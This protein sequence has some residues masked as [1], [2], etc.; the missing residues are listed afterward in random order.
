MARISR[1]SGKLLEE[2]HGLGLP[3]RLEIRPLLRLAHQV[4]PGLVPQR[5]GDLLG[6][7]VVQ[8][9]DQ[10][11]HVVGHV[12]QVQ[13][14]AAPIAGIEDVLQALG[15]L[16]DGLVVRQRAVAEVADAGQLGVRLTMRSV[17]SG[18]SFS[19]FRMSV[20]MNENS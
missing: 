8:P 14:V 16:D 10:V 13:T 2:G 19:F 5:P 4:G 6:Q 7:L 12:A 18:S 3:E 9:V 17:S 1:S 20:A 15:D 11:A